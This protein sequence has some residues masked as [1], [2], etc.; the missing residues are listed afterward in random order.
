[1]HDLQTVVSFTHVAERAHALAGRKRFLLAGIEMKK[2]QYELRFSVFEEANE[3]P[4][5]PITN[6]GIDD[7]GLY[8][9]RLPGLER[10]QR[11]QSRVI[12]VT[13]RQMQHQILLARDT[14]PRELV[15]ERV[16]RL[17]V[18]GSRFSRHGFNCR[19][20]G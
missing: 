5:W 2:A 20:L 14:E 18:F 17:F 9:P 16:A 19:S 11:S 8:L 10:G 7:R 15:L 4:S 12:L 13:E 6:V 3:L 1:M